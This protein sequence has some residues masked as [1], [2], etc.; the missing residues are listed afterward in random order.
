MVSGRFVSTHATPPVL[1]TARV[2]F[3]RLLAI[4]DSIN[5]EEVGVTFAP[6]VSLLADLY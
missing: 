6:I 1:V 5:K 4:V 3:D 2:N